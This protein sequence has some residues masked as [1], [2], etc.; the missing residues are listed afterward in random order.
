MS[1]KCEICVN[2][3]KPKPKP[4][5][6][7][8]LASK[9]NE[10][11]SIDLKFWKGIYFLVIVDIATR[12]CVACVIKDKKPSIIVQMFLRSWVSIFGAPNKVFDG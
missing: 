5:V 9:L 6:S 3:K 4:I 12:F 2:F 7:L 8:P 10:T 1:E 11:V